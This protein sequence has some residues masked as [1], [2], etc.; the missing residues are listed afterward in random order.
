M[1]ALS[2]SP[3]W[4]RSGHPIVRRY[5]RQPM[6]AYLQA[7]LFAMMISVFLMLGGLSI[8]VLYCLFS[9]AVLVQVAV[10]SANKVYQAR[11]SSTWDLVRIAPFSSRELLLS[12]WTA[13]VRQ[14]SRTWFMM[15]YRLLHAM[16]I[17]G[18]IVY[19]LLFTNTHPQQ[20]LLILL[21]G[22]AM[23]V[24]QPFAEMFF[25]GMVGLAGANRLRDQHNG[26]GFVVGVVVL[27]W[28]GYVGGV[29]ALLMA[30]QMNLSG[31]Q[32]VAIFVTPLILPALFGS[33]ALRI[34]E[35]ALR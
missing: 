25:C 35:T 18:V 13:S 20:A 12:L 22:T 27:Y 4:L 8:P 32:L 30:Q 3:R 9:L 2:I 28:L 24:V 7:L 16:T 17:I 14:L 21:T 34:A 10:S 5:V 19:T 26:Q 31:E 1:K 15:V 29:L 6:P 11:R 33:V 23:I